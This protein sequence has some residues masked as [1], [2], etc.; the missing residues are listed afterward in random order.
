MSSPRYT[1]DLSGNHW[2]MERARPGTGVQ[3]GFHDVPSEYQGIY[4]SWNQ[5]SV[6]GD[7]FTDLQRAGEIDDPFF[8]RNYHK[9]KW[10]T[11]YEW[12]YVTKFNLPE[13]LEGKRFEIHFEGV[14]YSF[15]AW[16]NGKPIGSHTGMFSSFRPDVTHALRFE[17]WMEG[18]NILMVK[19]DPAPKN[20]MNVG[21][22]KQCFQGDYMTGVVPTGI[23]RPVKVVATDAVKI[24]YARIE[25]PLGGADHDGP[26]DPNAPIN[27]TAVVELEVTNAGDQAVEVVFGADVS[28]ANDDAGSGKGQASHTATVQPGEST[29]KF[30]VPLEDVCRWWPWDMGN[31]PLYHAT[32]TAKIGDVVSDEVTERIG[33]REIVMTRNPG[34]TKEEAEFPWTF[35]MNGK[36]H[37]LRG[38]CWSGPPSLLYGRNNSAKYQA[39]IKQV[40]QAN[41]NHLRIFGWHPP[42]VPE[43]YELCDEAGIT[44]WTNFTFATQA[45]AATEEFME[46]AKND[47]IHIVKDRRNHP[48]AVMF[49]GGEEVFFSHAHAESDNRFIMEEM[50][51]AIEPYTSIPYGIASPLSEQF[52]QKMG[53]KAHDSTHANGH[54]YG[55]GR[56]MMEEFYPKL[57]Y[58]IVP[59]LTAASAPNIESLK[60]FIPE[61]ELWPMGPSWG[62]HHADIDIL[63]NLNFEVFGQ[64]RCDSLEDFVN[65]T[66]TAHGIIAHFALESLRRLK[67]KNSGIGLCHFMTHWPDIKWGIIDYYAKKKLSFAYVTRAY[68]PVL[69]SVDYVK[70]RW[71]PGENV[72]L[73]LYVINDT[74]D[75]KPGSTYRWSISTAQGEAARGEESVDISPDSCVE[76]KRINWQV[77]TDALPVDAEGGYAVPTFRVDVEL[78]DGGGNSIAKNFHVLLVDDQDQAKVRYRELNDA[79][80][81]QRD[82]LGK[83]YYRYFPEMYD[84]DNEEPDL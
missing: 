80:T 7:V 18:C 78:L 53:F 13:E 84:V 23:W 40:L 67:P 24:D 27:A 5:A 19:L 65:G 14:D 49:M 21:G 33:V 26:E 57:D 68:Q 35:T 51:R 69:P 76:L 34:Y 41:I 36:R 3:E 25:T 59:E 6:P 22:R 28:A 37:Y 29:V 9:T 62:Y 1:L 58:C 11:D 10:V 43:F 39:R 71:N 82:E 64:V 12:W 81:A 42:E 73:G 15:E 31:Q 8:G 56:T 79:N 2:K 16:L 32:I 48:S 47:C 50:G 70:R 46:G 44:V 66:Q 30:E 54:Y 75:A 38:A 17:Q 4:Y 63:K 45:Y 55:A 83:T 52:G 72:D 61:D 60:R 77:P 74:F 20:L